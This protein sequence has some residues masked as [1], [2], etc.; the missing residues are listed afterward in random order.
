MSIRSS[1]VLCVFLAACNTQAFSQTQSEKAEAF[2]KKV[3]SEYKNPMAYYPL[4]RDIFLPSDEEQDKID[5]Q[6]NYPKGALVAGNIIFIDDFEKLGREKFVDSVGRP[7]F[8][9][10]YRNVSSLSNVELFKRRQERFMKAGEN[11][12]LLLDY[13][14]KRLQESGTQR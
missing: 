5:L 11:K 8:R 14:F 1:V 13:N 10:R 12:L 9:H 6:H 3:L 7:L 2:I 4:R